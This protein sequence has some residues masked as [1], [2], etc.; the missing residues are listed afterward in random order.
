MCSI[1]YNYTV[2]DAYISL[3]Y[4][5]NLANGYGLVF[6]TDGSK[7]IEGYTNF[8]W[9]IL[10]SILF[11]IVVL[12]NILYGVKIIGILFGIGIIILTYKITY[13]VTNDKKVSIIAMSLISIFPNIAFWSIGGL[14]TSMY[15]FLLMLSVYLYQKNELLFSSI[16]FTLAAITRPEG[17]IFFLTFAL[18]EIIIFFNNKRSKEKNL[19]RLFLFLS[20]FILIF[21]CYYIW[22]FNF[23]GF[24]F[25]NSFYAKADLASL[26]FVFYRIFCRLPFLHFILPIL[27]FTIISFF[28]K[29][30]KRKRLNYIFIAFI[31]L[32]FLSFVAKREWMPGFRYELPFIPFMIIL[33]SIELKD[34]LNI[35][36][37]FYQFII[38]LTIILYLFYPAIDLSRSPRYTIEL[39][40][41]HIALGKWLEEYAPKNS[42]FA[43]WD[44]GAI[45][46]FSELPTIIEIHPEG[47]LSTFITHSGYNE[48]YLI[49]LKPSFIVLPSSDYERV[50]NNPIGEI[51]KIYK[52]NFFKENY[53]YLSTF[54]LRN[55]YNLRL[56]QYKEIQ[57][58]Q[59][60]LDE[61]NRLSKISIEL[62]L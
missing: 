28:E 21:G 13:F 2:D 18:Y 50:E 42:S 16:V 5:R 15:I 56:Y 47:I 8:L 17:L 39:E 14:E 4:A 48:D 36:K 29:Y 41:A 60:A 35:K 6:N 33:F 53:I 57:L 7:P 26:K 12:R 45:P 38:L 51:A 25:T 37:V 58:T 10:E 54:S 24:V 27:L 40:K 31:I 23:Y 19:K 49:R 1:F 62:N 52:N 11:K 32:F 61:M 9:I 55:D 20:T 59:T 46:Y 22:R 44:M 3:R 30:Q 34:I 43:G